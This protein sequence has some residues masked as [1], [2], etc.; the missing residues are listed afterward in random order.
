LVREFLVTRLEQD[1]WIDVGDNDLRC[2]KIASERDAF[3]SG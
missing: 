3:L 2:G 1:Q